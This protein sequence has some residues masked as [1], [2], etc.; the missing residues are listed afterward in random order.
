MDFDEL[1][2]QHPK[3]LLIS[4]SIGAILEIYLLY[5]I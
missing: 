2:F 3:C 5:S 4:I 1:D